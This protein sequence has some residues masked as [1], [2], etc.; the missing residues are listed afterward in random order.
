MFTDSTKRHARAVSGK[1]LSGFIAVVLAIAGI[2]GGVA[3]A[4]LA[5][6]GEL[7]GTVKDPTGAVVADA[8]VTATDTATGIST[9]RT[10][11]SSGEYDLSP[12]DAAIYTVTVTAKGFE[13]QTQDDVQVNALEIADYDAVLTVG[14]A[15][16]TV[17]VTAAPPALETSNA[18]LG[19]TMDQALYSALPIE[20]GAAGSP[21]QRRATD[22]AVL[23]PGVQGNE[24]N[25]NLTTNTGVVNGSGSRGAATAVYVN[26]RRFRWMR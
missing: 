18:T 17:T 26:G 22:F 15:S 7:K 12:L 16:E 9:T 14:S 5:G 8:S 24:T 11:N 3:H 19:A 1:F 2:A 6:K 20:M 23:M 25:G 10:S 21:D 4:Q 13:K